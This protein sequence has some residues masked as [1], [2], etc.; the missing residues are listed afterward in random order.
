MTNVQYAIP[1]AVM[2]SEFGG[3]FLVIGYLSDIWP[4]AFGHSRHD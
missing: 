2:Q 3:R 1:N 4:S